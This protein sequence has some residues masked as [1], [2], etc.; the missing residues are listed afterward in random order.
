MFE[1]NRKLIIKSSTLQ[2]NDIKSTLLP[3]TAN[4]IFNDKTAI[5]KPTLQ[6]QHSNISNNK[7]DDILSIKT[8]SPT[9]SLNTTKA[10][11]I[12]IIQTSNNNNI[13][14]NSL[15][16]NSIHKFDDENDTKK[17]GKFILKNYFFLIYNNMII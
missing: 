1:A 17:L 6:K 16:S 15:I 7:N 8:I 5:I 10:S 11:L 14:T 12:Q 4:I 2:S 13:S 3:A 9:V